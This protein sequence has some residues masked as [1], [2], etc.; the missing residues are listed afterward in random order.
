VLELHMPAARNPAQ[1]PP[2]LG[3]PLLGAPFC[4]PPPA[5]GLKRDFLFEV[6]V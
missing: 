5:L 6:D 1:S 3:L 2:G 4:G